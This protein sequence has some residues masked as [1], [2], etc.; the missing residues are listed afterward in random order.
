MGISPRFRQ[1][2]ILIFVLIAL[3]ACGWL[4][5]RYLL[6]I[7]EG[8]PSPTP[9]SILATHTPTLPVPATTTPT[10]TPPLAQA[11]PTSEVSSNVLISM[12]PG[13]YVGYDQLRNAANALPQARGSHF[14]IGWREIE[15]GRRGE[16]NW[17]PID[18]RLANV[19]PSKQ[20]IIRIVTRCPDSADGSRDECA[21][22]WA[23]KYDPIEV[24]LPSGCQA[25]RQRLNYLDPTVKQGLFD[26]IQALGERYRTNSQIGG[27]EIG[28][29]YAAEPVPYPA[30]NI[31][32]DSA[33]QKAAYLAHPGYTEKKWVDYHLQV[34]DQYLDAFADRKTLL[35]IISGSYAEKYHHLVV[36]HAV[37]RGVGLM[38]TNLH[39]DYFANRGSANGFCYWGYITEPG[40]SNESPE[41]QLAYIPLWPPLVVNHERVPIAFE[42]NNRFDNTGRLPVEGETFTRWSMLNGLD[43]HADYILPFNAGAGMPS[44][45]QYE[46]A[47]RFF[48]R[49]AGRSASTTPEVWIAF[50]SPWKQGA[51]CPDIF[52]YS[53]YLR[54]ELETLPYWSREVQAVV[55][56]IDAGTGV[57]D[58]GPQSDWRSA[59]ARQTTATWPLFNLDVDDRY[60]YDKT[61]AVDVTVTYFDHTYGGKWALVYDSVEGERLAGRVKLT[62]SN[63]WLSH[64]FHLTN[65]RFANRLPTFHPASTA[66]G[67]DLRL[68][69]AD[70]IDDIFSMVMVRRL[71]PTPT[72]TP[73][74]T[75]LPTATPTPTPTYTATP[76]PSG[77]SYQRLQ[78]GIG[79]AGTR[80]TYISRS[81]PNNSFQASSTLNL[82]KDVMAALLYF[83]LSSIPNGSQVE[84]ASL[85]LTRIDV[86]NT[87]V[88][89]SLYKILRRWTKNAT[90]IQAALDDSWEQPG[91]RGSHD[92]ASAPLPPAPVPVAP[93]GAVQLDITQLVKEWVD[94]PTSN[95]GVLLRG[96]SSV[97]A[98]FQFA[99]SE[100]PNIVRR[101]YIEIAYILPTATPTPTPTPTPSATPTTTPSPTATLTPTPA[102]SATPT[103]PA[104]ATPTATTIPSP[105][106]T[107]TMSPTPTRVTDT[108]SPTDTATPS[109]PQSATQTPVPTTATPTPEL[110]TCLPRF[111]STLSVGAEPKGIAAGPTGVFVALNSNASLVA[112]TLDGTEITIRTSG[113]GAN[114]VARWQ[115]RLYIA[116][117]DSATVSI[118]DVSQRKQIASLAVGAMPW[119]IAVATNR[120]YVVNFGD[121]SLSVFDLTNNRLLNTTPLHA[122]P[123]LVAA[124]GHRAYVSHLDGYISVVDDRGQ[125]IDTWG[126]I[127]GGDAFGVAVDSVQQRLFVSSRNGHNISVLDA[128]TG[129]DLGPIQLSS[130]PY[131]LAYNAFSGH[132]FAVDA[133]QNQLV[134]IDP[135]TSQVLTTLQL[136]PQNPDH[137]GQSLALWNNLIYVPAF[138][139]GVVDIFSETDC[140]P[141]TSTPPA[142]ATATPTFT[143]APTAT[144][145]PTI[146]PTPP[147]TVR[148]IKHNVNLR[149][150]PGR[151]FEILAPAP[152]NSEYQVNGRNKD[153]TWLHVCCT[154]AG[155][156]W[157][158][159]NLVR[160]NGSIANMPLIP[161]PTAT[162]TATFTATPTATP[163]PTS[164]ATP[165]PTATATVTPTATT[166]PTLTTTPTPVVTASPT[167]SPTPTAT[168]TATATPT[169]TPLP[170]TL[171]AKIE[172]V[173]PHGGA[174]V[175]D[176]QL[177]NITAH[178]YEDE[179]FNPV[180]CDFKGIVRLWR[181]INNEPARPIAVGQPRRTSQEGRTFTVWDFNDIDV[182]AANDPA[183]R[184]NFFVTVDGYQTRHNIWTHGADARTLAPEQDRPTAE[185]NFIPPA[186]D[187][188][189][190]IVWPHGN[191]PIT[192]AKLANI[193]ATLFKA[194]SLTALNVTPAPV[195]RLHWSVDNG[196]DQSFAET[197][198]GIPRVIMAPDVS[199]QMFDFNDIDVS[200][201]NDPQTHMYFWL[202]VEGVSAY[203]NIWSH[204]ASGLTRAPRQDVPARSCR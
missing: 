42:F 191:A 43:K 130:V 127:P 124:S 203:P 129:A 105:T 74:A 10:G 2:F 37:D 120:L 195:V 135:D 92:V 196:I 34:I 145:T 35:T 102:P 82:R 144:F 151:N 194:N 133:S 157:V 39:S 152:I 36:K 76:L 85:H 69:R 131:A 198:I 49:Y 106:V 53:F 185:I 128:E 168:L 100:H 140:V 148:V 83:D 176:A 7:L 125:L 115:N 153:G 166:T 56:E 77:I 188:K 33:A 55:N 90:Y 200:P 156:G 61:G 134:V 5:Q 119:G 121:P 155:A 28:V 88:D 159:A 204:G 163:S 68:D 181:A 84:R 72:P 147:V 57:F 101:P 9:T 19:D 3:I 137:G 38:L 29:G 25:P 187:A 60:L 141:P 40:F 201:A 116:H 46:D 165:S 108:P 47:W 1:L 11:S 78:Q 107:A 177:A 26:M 95:H 143:P 182:S 45:V 15:D 112:A 139:G 103:L 199:W 202:K 122:L 4:G 161:T 98:T 32:C 170:P 186:V 27:F 183:T 89:I 48:N 64:T 31:Y 179:Q 67:F 66:P 160:L 123:A 142:T 13:M 189:I 154:D 23:L 81:S 146:T 18:E 162:A 58:I 17:A 63:R 73:T 192:T 173:W 75:P 174:P 87:F 51:W 62:G 8:T 99:S 21:P 54:S 65:A 80:D 184:L 79:Y 70:D 169:A 111:F 86:N 109:P 158:R 30:T 172:I 114:G 6:P 44:N 41:A 118:V 117:R 171:I 136:S 193:S 97:N 93:F 178:L 126:P 50:R 149:V 14:F 132:L 138:A 16:Y 180:V 104:T 164:T 190:E 96:E 197:P 59:Y 20:V 94:D 91:V 113:Q 110:S 22:R 24:E 175:E 167:P 150:G 12:Q 52:D 71:P